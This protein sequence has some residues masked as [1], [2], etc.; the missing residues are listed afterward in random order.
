MLRSEGWV[1]HFAV[2]CLRMSRRSL[3]QQRPVALSSCCSA[4]TTVPAQTIRGTNR[5]RMGSKPT[6]G[7]AFLEIGKVTW[8]LIDF[9]KLSTR[10]WGV[11]F[12]SY[13][14]F[15]LSSVWRVSEFLSGSGN[16]YNL[17]SH[18]GRD[19]VCLWIHGW[20][21]HGTGWETSQAILPSKRYQSW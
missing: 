14:Y 21:V 2:N 6:Q 8:S 12:V 10:F 17:Q 4:L 9:L 19:P 1:R 16:L 7:L 13:M 18:A 3:P 11:A 20:E 5:D 15:S